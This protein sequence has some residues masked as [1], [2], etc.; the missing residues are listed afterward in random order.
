MCLP[1]LP[2]LPT[3]CKEEIVIVCSV[4]VFLTHGF[5]AFWPKPFVKIIA[6]VGQ[7]VPCAK[8]PHAAVPLSPLDLQHSQIMHL[9]ELF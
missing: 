4:C 1:L 6:Q 5:Q 7:W 9:F 2:H 3:P 8:K